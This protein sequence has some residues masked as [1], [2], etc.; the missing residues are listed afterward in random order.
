MPYGRF[1]CILYLSFT[2]KAFVVEPTFRCNLYTCGAR[3]Y[4]YNLSTSGALVYNIFY[5]N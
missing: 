1:K 2:I 4:V 3:V 5:L